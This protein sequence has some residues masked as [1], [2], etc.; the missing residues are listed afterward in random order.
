MKVNFLTLI[1]I[2]Y[3]ALTEHMISIASFNIRISQPAL[4]RPMGP[5]NPAHFVI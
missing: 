2:V 1:L 5:W 4:T 3:T